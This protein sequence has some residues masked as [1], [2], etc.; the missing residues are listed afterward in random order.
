[1]LMAGSG[2]Q[3]PI[4]T[5]AQLLT[6]QAGTPGRLGENNLDTPVAAFAL[7]VPRLN[8]QLTFPT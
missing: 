4:S 3:S 5:A 7:A 8:C 2:A 1:M 6:C